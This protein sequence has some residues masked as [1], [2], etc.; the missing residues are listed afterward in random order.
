MKSDPKPTKSPW[1]KTQYSNILGY[2][3]SGTYFAR[4]RTS[5][6][7]IRSSLETSVLSV[8]KLHLADLEKKERKLAEHQAAT[9]DGRLTFDDALAIY[10]QRLEED[11]SL[12]RRTREYHEQQIKALLKSWTEIKEREVRS[13]TKSDCLDCAAKFEKCR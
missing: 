10:K 12:K 2:K 1:Q 8:A 11:G 4:I 5:G 6:K 9:S 7:L 3:S 13:I